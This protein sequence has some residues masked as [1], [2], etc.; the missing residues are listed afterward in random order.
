MGDP[1]GPWIYPKPYQRRVVWWSHGP[2]PW[3]LAVIWCD[4]TCA[5]SRSTCKA[6]ESQN[7]RKH[8]LNRL[9]RRLEPHFMGSEL[10]CGCLHVDLGHTKGHCYVIFGVVIMFLVGTGDTKRKN[11][12]KGCSGLRL[13]LPR[14]R[15]SDCTHGRVPPNLPNTWPGV[16]GG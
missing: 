2:P 6:A 4:F 3:V 10:G 15:W 12:E 13:G 9:S 8:S 7:T 1:L 5:S 14:S 11:I 16:L